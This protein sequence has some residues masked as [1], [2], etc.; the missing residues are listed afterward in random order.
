MK[1]DVSS[2]WFVRITAPWD[3]IEVKYKS[4]LEYIDVKE[5]AIGYHI[6]TKTGKAHAH[7]AIRM[8]KGL[9]KQSLDL[10]LKKLFDVKGSDYS[11]KV[12]DGS[13][14]V[15]SYLYHDTNGKV[16]IN[17]PLTPEQQTEVNNLVT[18]YNEI[19]TTAKS[20]ATYKCV[21]HVLEAIADS[22][23]I[24]S[25]SDIVRYIMVGVRQGRWHPPGKFQL[26]KYVDEIRIKQGSDDDA[27]A[28]ID[29]MVHQFLQSYERY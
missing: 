14:K 9:Q 22:K 23:T 20:K 17:M 15:L 11:S 8:L 28:V 12:W 13:Y 29:S 19:V 21:D 7:I 5:T 27:H 10:R 24:W 16:V 1:S 2:E 3:H 26:E 4:L 25:T 6:G 18:V